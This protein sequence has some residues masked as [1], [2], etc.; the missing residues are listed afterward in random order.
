MARLR[1]RQDW[2]ATLGRVADTGLGVWE[3]VRDYLAAN[4]DERTLRKA[5]PQLAAA[6]T[7]ACLLYYAKLPEEIAV[8]IAESDA[9]TLNTLES[10]SPGLVRSA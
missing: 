7:R 2:Q 3:V 8:E 10:L 4:R 5:F 6:Q 1:G 9:L